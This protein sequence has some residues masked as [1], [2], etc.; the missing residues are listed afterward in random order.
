MLMGWL[1]S[2]LSYRPGRFATRQFDNAVSMPQT[3]R[4]MKLPN[5]DV[6]LFIVCFPVRMQ[7]GLSLSIFTAHR[8]FTENYTETEQVFRKIFR[9]FISICSIGSGL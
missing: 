9:N 3:F 4:D 6:A 1:K 5:C 8:V 7:R 2:F